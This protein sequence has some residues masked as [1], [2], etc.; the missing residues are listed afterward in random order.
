MALVDL[1]THAKNYI[2]KFS[3]LDRGAITK[4]SELL[5]VTVNIEIRE[6][7]ISAILLC[8]TTLCLLLTCKRMPE[9]TL[10]S[11]TAMKQLQKQ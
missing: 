9:I 6:S 2:A 10:R 7:V 3:Q 8:S 5:S 11:T 4:K 1:Q